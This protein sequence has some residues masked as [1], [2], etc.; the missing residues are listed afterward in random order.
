MVI[1]ENQGRV[2]KEKKNKKA[3]DAKPE[4]SKP[5]APLRERDVTETIQTTLVAA[6]SSHCNTP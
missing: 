3:I 4:I 2:R 6:I 5:Y 1:C